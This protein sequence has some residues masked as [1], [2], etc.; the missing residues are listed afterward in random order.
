M[1]TLYLTLILSIFLFAFAK[2]QYTQIYNDGLALEKRNDYYN[3]ILKYTAANV[4][5]DK[6]KE[7]DLNNRIRYCGQMLVR[8][9]VIAENARKEVLKQK[10]KADSLLEVANAA[11]QKVEQ[12][13]RK[14]EIA[15]F[16]QAVFEK[17]KDW[18]GFDRYNWKNANDN[19]TVRGKEILEKI[20]S[21]DLSYNALLRIPIQVLK[22]P[23]LKHLN[24]LGNPDINW[25]R[26]A[27][28]LDKLNENTSIYITISNIDNIPDK[29]HK[30]ISGLQILEAGFDGIQD[31]ILALKNLTFLDIAGGENIKNNFGT[32]PDALF[33]LNKLQKLNLSNCNI[34]KLPAEIG[35]L[36]NLNSLHLYNNMLLELP[37]EIGLLT[38][39]T[40]LVLDS[41][42]IVSL[43]PSIGNLTNLNYLD[44]GRNKLTNFPTE[45]VKLK[46]LSILSLYAN[47]LS[48]L[49]PEI[50]KLKNLTFLNLENNQFS[51]LPTEITK[52]KSLSTLYLNNNNLAS[53][54]SEIGKLKNLNYL[55]LGSNHLSD[56]PFEMEKLKNLIYLDL[57][58]N[59]FTEL[60]EEVTYLYDLSILS[61]YGNK[62]SSLPSALLDL[63]AI[64]ELD[65]G[66]NLF[67]EIPQVIAQLN[68]L[69][70]FNIG[71]NPIKNLPENFFETPLSHKVNYVDWLEACSQ[72]QDNDLA[73][74]VR[75]SI[76]EREFETEEYGNFSWSLIF[77]N[78]LEGA[79]WAGEK[80]VYKGGESIGFLSNLAM[81]YLYS[82][83]FEKANTIYKEY[84]NKSDEGG[85]GKEIFMTDLEAVKNAGIKPKNQA[86]V[87]KIIKLLK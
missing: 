77:C 65:L 38:N 16:D 36:K 17:N 56:L 33:Q 42:Q 72:I 69:R 7:S 71:G 24:L 64:T 62:L 58:Y 6:P 11:L 28:T 10:Q 39:L 26:S 44:L 45:I 43:P 59:Q 57:S 63:E 76:K 4:C 27:E 52:L 83:Q 78:D 3:A 41:N 47:K 9:N 86:D 49:S 32:L 30:Y 21:L 66:A 2:A 53:L 48:V 19:E 50:I 75:K 85:L 14:V 12:M 67:T 81:A 84:K 60:P 54:S 29:Y 22:C 51:V 70:I 40:E 79:I 1:K 18:K 20:D 87:D 15:M 8:Q 46:N 82:G 5:S 35:N 55:G 34:S 74:T 80:Y 73:L 31:N 13:Q 37:S 61:M 68:Y 23:N 25:I